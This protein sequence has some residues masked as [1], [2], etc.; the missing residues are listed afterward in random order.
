MS[1][2]GINNVAGKYRDNLLEA[3]FNEFQTS[4]LVITDRLH[5]MIFA[6]ITQTPCIVFGSLTHKTTESH[7][8]LKNLGYI[9]FCEDINSLEEQ[10]EKVANV[11]E[12]QYDNKFAREKIKEVLKKEIEEI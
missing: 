10:I 6:A 2:S 12:P 1:V 3:K 11:K 4:K 8:W 5:G 7:A 9:Q